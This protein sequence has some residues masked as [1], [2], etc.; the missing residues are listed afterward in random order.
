MHPTPKTSEELHYVRMVR[1]GIRFLVSLRTKVYVIGISMLMLL[2][3]STGF[4][5]RGGWVVID[6]H[7]FVEHEPQN[8]LFLCHIY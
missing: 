6:D 7:F 4:F 5:R 3:V 8:N 1:G 2:G